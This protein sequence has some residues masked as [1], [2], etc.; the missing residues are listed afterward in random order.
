MMLEG[1]PL[2]LEGQRS[3]LGALDGQEVCPAATRA[4]GRTGADGSAPPSGSRS[5]PPRTCGPSPPLLPLT[6]G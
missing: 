1:G 2:S 4:A 6:G 3:K 5:P